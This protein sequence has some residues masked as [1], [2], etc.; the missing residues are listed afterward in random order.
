MTDEWGPLHRG[1]L[2]TCPDDLALLAMFKYP[3]TFIVWFGEGTPLPTPPEEQV[4]VRLPM[5]ADDA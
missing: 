2:V 1:S 3:R 5:E 4:P